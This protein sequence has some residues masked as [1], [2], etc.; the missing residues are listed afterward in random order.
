MLFSEQ[1]SWICSYLFILVKEQIYFNFPLVVH[2][3]QNEG[4]YEETVLEEIMFLI[5]LT[6]ILLI[7]EV[8]RLYPLWLKILNVIYWIL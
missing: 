2:K 1:N 3:H 4:K 8:L 7:F 5:L 6:L